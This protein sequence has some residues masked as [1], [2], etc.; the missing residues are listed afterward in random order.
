MQFWAQFGGHVESTD[1]S[2]A[3]AAQREAREESRIGDL[4]LL[5]PAIID[6]HDLHAGFSC[7]AP[8]GCRVRRCC[9]PI[10]RHVSE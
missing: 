1:A 3:E 6:R 8:L 4:V 9:C 7:A 5:C 10:C 2:V